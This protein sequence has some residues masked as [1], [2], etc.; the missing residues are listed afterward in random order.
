MKANDLLEVMY[1]AAN[2]KTKEEKAK[3][4]PIADDLRVHTANDLLRVLMVVANVNAKRLVATDEEKARIA[5]R[6]SDHMWRHFPRYDLMTCRMFNN[7]LQEQKWPWVEDL[8]SEEERKEI[9]AR[10][11]K[12]IGEQNDRRN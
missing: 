11:E 6:A 4:A 10:F 7:L 9:M 5:W 3:I 1:I 8:W 2:A 12:V